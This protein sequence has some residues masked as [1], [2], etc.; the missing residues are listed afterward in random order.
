MHKD[1]QKSIITLRSNK[2]IIATEN[3]VT[4]LCIK[5]HRYIYFIARFMQF[6]SN[7]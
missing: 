4:T 5:T 7:Q 2:Q 1:L 3:E 6:R